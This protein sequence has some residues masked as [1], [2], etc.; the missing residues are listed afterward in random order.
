MKKFLAALLFVFTFA[1]YSSA[2]TNIADDF[3]AHFGAGSDLAAYNKDLNTMIGLADFHTGKATSFPGFDVGA[4]FSA[5]KPSDKNNISSEDY[6]Y[7][8]FITAETNIPVLGVGVVLRGTDW[9]GFESLGGG[10]K[11][12]FGFLNAIHVSVAGFYDRAK[13]E[14]YTADHYSASAVA[15]ANVLFFTPYVGVGYDYGELKTR[16]LAI[17]D[18]TSDGSARF[19]AGVN[20]TPFPF[21]YVFGAYTKTENNHGLQAGIGLNF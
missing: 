7:T 2:A 16:N 12:N 10:L 9:N 15:S 14:W 1:D 18:S 5:I 11:Y 19:T 3:R 4:S 20:M 6:L 8:G 13:T 21:V 17:S